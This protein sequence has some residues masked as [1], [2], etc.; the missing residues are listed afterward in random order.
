MNTVKMF[1]IIL[2]RQGFFENVLNLVFILFFSIGRLPRF[3]ED[4]YGKTLFAHKFRSVR[5]IATVLLAYPRGGWRNWEYALS[6]FFTEFMAFC[7]S[8]RLY[9]LLFFIS[10]PCQRTR[11]LGNYLFLICFQSFCI[12]LLT[13]YLRHS[14]LFR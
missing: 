5:V 2:G 8:S 12:I 13:V 10:Q 9:Y 4:I 7:R 14:Y 3:I 11:Y 6:Y 1:I